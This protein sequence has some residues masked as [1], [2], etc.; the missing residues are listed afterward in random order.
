MLPNVSVL[1]EI[2][3][4]INIYVFYICYKLAEPGNFVKP[5]FS[6]IDIF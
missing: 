5:Y 6:L 3:M 2:Q 1:A 4:R